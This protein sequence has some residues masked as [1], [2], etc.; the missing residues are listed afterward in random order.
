MKSNPQNTIQSEGVVS[1]TLVE[2]LRA[3]ASVMETGE[4]IA[5]GSD[6]ALMREAADEIERLE[7]QLEN[8]EAAAEDRKYE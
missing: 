3:K 8:F 2:R 1:A 4:K 7:A 6:T 5:A